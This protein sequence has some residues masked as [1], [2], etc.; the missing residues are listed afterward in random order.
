M[1]EAEAQSNEKVSDRDVAA[2]ILVPLEVEIK[3]PE[4]RF[5]KQLRQALSA[6]SAAAGCPLV[7]RKVDRF[8]KKTGCMNLDRAPAGQSLTCQRL[9]NLRRDV[10]CE[11]HL[12]SP[13]VRPS[14]FRVKEIAL[15]AWIG[16]R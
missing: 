10:D 3:T 14:L 9:L 8:F 6:R 5:R 2:Q 7:L 4:W 12:L 15:G 13:N 11:C 16:S 1:A